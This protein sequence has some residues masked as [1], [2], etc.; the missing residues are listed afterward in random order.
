[1]IAWAYG[2][3]SANQHPEALGGIKQ[4]T[5]AY[6]EMLAYRLI[7]NTAGQV[8]MLLTRWTRR[9]VRQT[10]PAHPELSIFPIC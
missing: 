5:R 8:S 6:E 2:A 9:I 3:A 10:N 4:P 1:M 7:N